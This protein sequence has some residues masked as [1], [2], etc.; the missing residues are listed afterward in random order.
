MK[1]AETRNRTQRESTGRAASTLLEFVKS[2][3]L[4][5]FSSMKTDYFA[6]TTGRNGSRA[7]TPGLENSDLRELK[8]TTN[9]KKFTSSEFSADTDRSKGLLNKLTEQLQLCFLNLEKLY[10]YK[11]AF[12]MPNAAEKPE[13]IH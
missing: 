6:L 4:V 2:V 1:K 7:E 3:P 12:S 13:L 10:L 9:S 5:V 8:F 11:E